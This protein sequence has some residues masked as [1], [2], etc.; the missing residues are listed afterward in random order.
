MTA[1][2]PIQELADEIRRIF[3]TDHHQADISIPAYLDKSLAQVSPS[4]RLRLLQDLSTMFGQSPQ[5]PE[6]RSQEDLTTPDTTLN[7]KMLSRLITLLTGKQT[8]PA[9]RSSDDLLQALADS[10]D[11][12][13]DALNRLVSVINMAQSN[14]SDDKAVCQI[15]GGRLDGEDPSSFEAY[16]GQ[17]EKI[18]LTT[19]KAFKQAATATVGEILNELDP[20]RIAETNAGGKFRL[21]ARRKAEF[22]DAYSAKFDEF[23]DWFE[24]GRFMQRLLKAFEKYCQTLPVK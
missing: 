9:Q 8:M 16:L 18:F 23:R 24:S 15:I 19:H 1:G 17:I 13:F 5:R 14:S 3:K 22:Y 21:G 12:V 11:T 4:E 6:P 2:I 10:I 7:R 20:Q